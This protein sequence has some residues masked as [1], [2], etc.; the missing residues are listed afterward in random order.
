M[1]K[2]RKDF[3][4]KV[5]SVIAVV[6][7]LA[8]ATV[9]PNSTTPPN[10]NL[11]KELDFND[12]DTTSRYLC[13]LLSAL[14]HKTILLDGRPPEEAFLRV[15]NI[16]TNNPNVGER[17]IEITRD[18]EGNLWISH[19]QGKTY[20]VAYK[21]GEFGPK[22]K[23]EF[24]A[25]VNEKREKLPSD[26]RQSSTLK[27]VLFDGRRLFEGEDLVLNVEVDAIYRQQKINLETHLGGCA[28]CCGYM[29]LKILGTPLNAFEEY[30]KAIEESG[31]SV[32]DET[33]EMLTFGSIA[34]LA[35]VLG[36][37]TEL[38]LSES[39]EYYEERLARQDTGDM[40]K[41]YLIGVKNYA[42]HP[43]ANI[44]Y[45][46]VLTVS[47]IEKAL[48]HD[49]ALV[50]IGFSWSG[51]YGQFVDDAKGNTFLEDHAVIIDRVQTVNDTKKVHVIDPYSGDVHEKRRNPIGER[52]YW[53]TAEQFEKAE[54]KPGGAIIIR[55]KS[56][57][58]RLV[59]IEELIGTLRPNEGLIIFVTTADQEEIIK[60]HPRL[61]RYKFATCVYN[62]LPL[63]AREDFSRI[64]KNRTFQ[65]DG[66]LRDFTDYQHV[67]KYLTQK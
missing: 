2:I 62:S 40:E 57:E 18:G 60:K 3:A 48:Q 32:I 58:E 65:R 61:S 35:T 9:Y 55:K 33:A 28:A 20:I 49:N 41:A 37:S 59:E 8:T 14:W 31:G 29:A 52:E 13:V 45:N 51:L 46:T 17:G 50:V 19:E 10:S 44:A 30:V 1:L 67:K 22:S 26:T 43:N 5:V 16:V 53:L 24:I 36:F 15:E 66:Y 11:R 42:Q 34:T 7:F 21:T 23:E 54:L 63:E 4:I 38:T 39:P 6:T 12:T 64:L 56:F 25:S 27:P 47:D